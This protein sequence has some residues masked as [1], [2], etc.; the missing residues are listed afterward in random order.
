MVN[1][2]RRSAGDRD[3]EVEDAVLAYLLRHPR[4]ADTLDGIV[5]WWLPRQ[6][7]ETARSRI[8]RSL[9]NLVTRG[10]VRRVRLPDGAVFYTLNDRSRSRRH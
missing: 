3:K 8:A 5:S 6:R 10:L 1:D 2:R 9:G 4:A 7:Y